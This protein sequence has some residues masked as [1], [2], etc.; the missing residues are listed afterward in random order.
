MWLSIDFTTHKLELSSFLRSKWVSICGT[1]YLAWC[2]VHS[3]NH[4]IDKDYSLFIMM[5]YCVSGDGIWFL[6]SWR[7]HCVISI[8]EWSAMSMYQTWTYDTFSQ[9]SHWALFAFCVHPTQMFGYWIMR[10]VCSHW[11]DKLFLSPRVC[12]DIEISNAIYWLSYRCVDWSDSTRL[13]CDFMWYDSR[14][15][16]PN[17]IG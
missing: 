5:T 12:V 4:C 15:S 14:W 11:F 10:S 16:I 8:V 17:I 1:L 7:I 13:C 6:P 3:E 9:G 2:V